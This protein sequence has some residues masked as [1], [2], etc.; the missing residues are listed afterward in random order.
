M[1]QICVVNGNSMNN[2]LYNNQM[3]V[4]SKLKTAIYGDIV[5]IYSD[6]LN[7]LLCKRVIAME[8][9]EV[10]IK[11]KEVYVNGILQDEPYT[12]YDYEPSAEYNFVVDEGCV[13]VM[14]DNRNHSTD[15]RYLGS[16]S[17]ENIRSVFLFNLSD[18]LHANY[19]TVQT[20]IKIT[21]VLL[22]VVWIVSGIKSKNK[23][24]KKNEQIEVD[25]KSE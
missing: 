23:V 22:F 7:E 17:K 3:L 6:T 16:I 5:S 10:I 24:E 8:G 1:F 20:S 4:Q 13:F 9:D 15:S 19:D 18:I 2:T 21:W 14:G 25:D 12:Y 11:G